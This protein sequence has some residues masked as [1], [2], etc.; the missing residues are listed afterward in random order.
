MHP[1]SVP[2]RT[3]ALTSRAAA[4]TRP[5]EHT[6]HPSPCLPFLQSMPLVSPKQGRS[7]QYHLKL[8][9]VC[10]LSH[11]E[12][13]SITSQMEQRLHIGAMDFHA[14]LLLLPQI[15]WLRQYAL[16]SYPSFLFQTMYFQTFK[17]FVV[18]VHQQSDES[19]THWKER[20]NHILKPYRVHTY[21][22]ALGKLKLQDLK[23]K[24]SCLSDTEV[25]FV[26]HHHHQKKKGET[27][28]PRN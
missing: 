3:S 11:S 20:I 13:Y 9:K 6:A 7:Q 24:T 2:H 22:P 17:T 25:L 27:E 1:S 15:F 4:G 26:P 28:S 8:L 14:L 23:F 5:P 16:P 12:M 10:I 19:Q 21:N 18:K